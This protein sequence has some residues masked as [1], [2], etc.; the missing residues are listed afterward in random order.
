LDKVNKIKTMRVNFRF[1]GKMVE[2]IFHKLNK[3]I[4]D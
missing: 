4:P 1:I 2:V 3:K